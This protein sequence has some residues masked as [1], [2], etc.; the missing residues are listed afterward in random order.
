MKHL[1]FLIV[2]AVILIAPVEASAPN[3]P[4]FFSEATPETPAP[5]IE[6]LLVEYVRQNCIGK[7]YSSADRLGPD[8]FDCSGLVWYCCS[9][10]GINMSDGNTDSQLS[11]GEAV[12]LSELIPGDIVF[13]DYD[14]DGTTDHA[15][16]YSG[17]GNIIHATT[18]GVRET[19]LDSP[20]GVYERQTFLDAACTARRL[21]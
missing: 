13:F 18:H 20:S 17:D 15:A 5:Q 4:E 10:T 16:I 19:P 1:I 12:S 8:S 21:K 9:G 14:N 3:A 7:P 2:C 11:Y 6:N